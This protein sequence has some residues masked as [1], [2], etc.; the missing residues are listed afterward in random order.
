V[1][2]AKSSA[3]V[4]DGGVDLQDP[5]V[6]GHKFARQAVLAEMGFPVPQFACVPAS[7][8]DLSVDLEINE[9]L[10]GKELTKEK[11]VEHSALLRDRVRQ[12]VVPEQLRAA[13]LEAFDRLVGPDGLVA[14]RA[15]VVPPKDGHGGED[16]S[17]DPFAGMSDSYLYVGRDEAVERVLACWS[18][19]FNSEAVLYRV[20]RGT[21]PFAARVA[22]GIQRMVMGVRSFVAFTRD[23]RDGESRC[24]VAA[25]YGIG[26]GVVQ[27]RADIDHFF[28]DT[29]SGTIDPHIVTKTEAVGWDP[30]RPLDG[31]VPV[32]V[33]ASL[34]DQPVLSKEQLLEIAALAGRVEAHFGGAQ[35]IEGT[36]T[37]DGHIY[38]VQ[39]RPAGTSNAVAKPTV[40]LESPVIW[41]NSNVTESFPGISCALTYSMAQQLYEVGLADLYRRMGVSDSVLSRQQPSLRRMVGYL[42]G[43]IYYQLDRWYV[44]H[45]TIRC[46][47]PLWSTWEQAIGLQGANADGT[48]ESR[49][50]ISDLV[51]LAEIAGR[52]V[53]HPTRI[54][55]F[56]AWWDDYHTELADT[57]SLTP[58]ELIAAYDALWDEVSRRWGVTLVNG[59]FLFAVTRLANTLMSRW[60]P[61]ADPSLLH[62][63]LVGGPQNRSA[64][65]LHSAVDLASL[66]NEQ[67]RKALLSGRP[68][69]EVWRELSMGSCDPAFFD[70]LSEHLRLY[71][72]RA[73]HDLKIETVT[74]RQEPWQVLRTV[75]SYLRQDRTTES[76]L[77]VGREV[78]AK[79]ER[80]LRSRLR[81]PLKRT[82]V[83]GVFAAMRN[84]M[85]NREDTRFCRSQLFGDF[86]AL[87]LRL[88]EE[89]VKA[90]CLNNQRDVLHLSSGE[91]VGAFEGTLPGADL[92]S[93]VRVRSAELA[94]WTAADSPLPTR[95]ESD[96]NVP[97]FAILN[98]RSDDRLTTSQHAPV[99]SAE[100]DASPAV[101]KGLAS[102]AGTVRG[103]AKVVLDPQSSADECE[104]RILV[105]RETD[106][107]WLFL[108]MSAKALVVERGTLLSHT[109]ITGR[110]LGIPTVVAVRNATS[111]IPDGALI[112]VDGSAGTVRLLETPS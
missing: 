44:M 101:V 55:R 63:M 99:V 8:F 60:L 7:I 9:A 37:S 110:L 111:L 49:R 31:P 95:L 36:I 62:G 24:V 76:S 71:G 105:A 78:R 106:P 16:S 94:R 12:V 59:I 29:E 72:D 51:N 17:E 73:L 14:V 102:S 103:V 77:A 15:C 107:G 34:S 28:V 66:A 3:W 83:K 100:S 98:D 21:E 4:I 75:R 89:L 53:A 32:P 64:Q 70:A 85:K 74:P 40:E 92:R 10:T 47:R 82:V 57:S 65:A 86:R 19:A 97:V 52:F 43:R 84:L 68:E 56:L 81:N 25:A 109:A 93:L 112:E 50:R 23:P 58:Q 33:D 6:V 35:D 104:D 48:A 39:A 46:F 22:V 27:E 11:L 30:E 45:G 18:S 69:E 54:R 91:L 5:L 26:E 20:A 1:Q 96:R 2:H 61:E 79:A 87:L 108:M 13:V 80:E 41:D 42:H 88:G 38:L 67:T 90:G